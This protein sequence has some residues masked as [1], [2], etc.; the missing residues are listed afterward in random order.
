MAGF[1]EWGLPALEMFGYYEDEW[2]P[3]PPWSY[4]VHGPPL[5]WVGLTF[6]QI[7]TVSTAMSRV[8]RFIKSEDRAGGNDAGSSISTQ[9]IRPGGKYCWCRFWLHPEG[10]GTITHGCPLERSPSLV[11]NCHTN[12]T[13]RSFGHQHH[14]H[15][16]SKRKYYHCFC[17]WPQ[18]HHEDHY[19][20]DSRSGQI[21]RTSPCHHQRT[22]PGQPTF[23]A[24]RFS[25]ST[26]ITSF[27]SSLTHDRIFHLPISVNCVAAI[28]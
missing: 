17:C 27:I 13:L 6:I 19:F 3:P 22:T 1:H 15:C 7:T 26:F 28:A 5:P 12:I 10:H 21:L 25:S 4:P 14:C 16:Q 23:D 11:D 20:N 18:F 24:L 2:G 9:S 8:E